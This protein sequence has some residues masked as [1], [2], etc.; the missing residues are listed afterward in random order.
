MV[1]ER[2]VY[3]ESI[4]VGACINSRNCKA[5]ATDL[6]DGW[7][8]NCWDKG[9]LAKERILDN[10]KKRE[11]E[12]KSKQLLKELKQRRILRLKNIKSGRH[13]KN[14]ACE[15]HKNKGFNSD[16]YLNNVS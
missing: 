4:S 6:A 14:C 10:V 8:V 5:Y 3:P 2:E 11:E 1:F 15:Y 16:E 13:K 9:A 7:C 12:K